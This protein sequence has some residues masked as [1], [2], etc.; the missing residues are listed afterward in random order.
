MENHPE[1]A[2]SVLSNAASIEA[3]TQER[4]SCMATAFT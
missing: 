1:M 2:A 3:I 4:C